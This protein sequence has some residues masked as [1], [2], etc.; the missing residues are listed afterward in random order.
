MVRVAAIDIGT[1]STRLL[2]ADVSGGSA[3][4]VEKKL[5]TTR[6]GEGIN[7]GALLPAAMERTLEAIGACYEASLQLGAE[8]VVAAA[9]SAVRDAANQSAFLELVKQRFDLPVRVLSGPEEAALSYRGVLSGL[10]V[11]PRST[12]VVDVG[13]GST[14]LIWNGNGRPECVSVK[15]GA[16]RMSGSGW[17]EQLIAEV[18]K[19]ALDMLQGCRASCLAGVGGTVTTLAAVDLELAVYD[20]LLIHGYRLT[21]E[22]VQRIY[23]MLKSMNINERKRLPGLQP[24]RADIIAA[25]VAIVKAVLDGIGLDS[26][27][28]SECDILHG[29]VLEKS[30]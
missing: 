26:L 10:P 4:A 27:L 19:P 1:N 3:R 11:D 22:S 20:P 21:A 8:R 9:T 16:V 6:L 25:G 14:E 29:L 18:L 28:V 7:A 13:G 30:I 2:V 5:M 17:S 12:V 23:D 24:E 15:A